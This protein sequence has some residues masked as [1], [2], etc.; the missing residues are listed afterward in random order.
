MSKRYDL[1]V[2]GAGPAGYAAAIRAAQLGMKVVCMDDWI[3]AGGEPALGGTCLN[4]GCIPSKALLEASE[5]YADMGTTYAGWGIRAKDV[6]LDLAAMMAHKQSIVTRM[7]QGIA[8]LFRANGVHSLSGRGRLLA[9]R[10]VEFTP[11]DGGEPETYEAEHVILAAGSRPVELAAVPLHE[12]I[13]VDSSGALAFDD[14]PKRLGVIGAGVIGVEL[15]SVWRRLGAEVVLLEAQTDFLSVCDRQVAREALR[16]FRTQGLDIR[17]GARV[18]GCAVKRGKVEL[19]YQDDAGVEHTEKF[20]RLIVAVGRQPNTDGLFASETGL[21]LDEW[22]FVHVDAYCLTSVPGVYAVGDLVRGPMLAHKGAGEGIMVVERIAGHH[23]RVNYETI[24]SV[25]YTQP[26]IAWAGATEQSL[27]AEGVA[28]RTGVFPFAANARAHAQGEPAGFVK[29]LADAETDRVL[30]VHMIG[31]GSSELIAGAVLAMEF[32]A[33]SE[34][35]G[36]TMF[37]HPTLS[38]ALHEAAL[39]VHGRAIHVAKARK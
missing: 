4:V 7:T 28:H 15:G 14:V 17:L 32:G 36:M 13:V 3:G 21:L 9:N 24:P 5:V 2:I 8:I 37:A 20:D 31:P 35:V 25:I 19:D 38:E 1:I 18:T 16:L 26:E 30:G 33:S 29:V 34:D 11:R 39:G 27:E 22:G 23:A 10:A 12:N 6:E